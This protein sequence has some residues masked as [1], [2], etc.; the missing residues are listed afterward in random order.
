M[1]ESAGKFVD[2]FGSPFSFFKLFVRRNKSA[3]LYK[4]LNTVSGLCNLFINS[5]CGYTTFQGWREASKEG[6]YLCRPLS[7]VL[8]ELIIQPVG[9]NYLTEITFVSSHGHSLTSIPDSFI[10]D[11]YGRCLPPPVGNTHTDCWF[12]SP[13]LLWFYHFPSKNSPSLSEAIKIKSQR[14]KLAHHIKI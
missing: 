9:F 2:L 7:L 10:P 6:L 1:Q 5:T 4:V 3:N 12:T 11:F 14:H 13:M 8:Y